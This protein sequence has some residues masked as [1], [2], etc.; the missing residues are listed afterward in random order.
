MIEFTGERV[1]PGQVDPDLWNEHYS[2]YL[3]AARL[4]RY[5]RVVDLGCGA[6][7][8]SALLAQS[9][10]QVI[11]VDF[12]ADAV[13][14]A[15]EANSHLAQVHTLQASASQ[16]PLAPNSA[17]LAVAFEVIE[18]LD[19]WAGL[20]REARRILAPGG[21]FI[22]STPNKDYYNTQRGAHGPNPFHTHEFTFPEFRDALREVFPHVSL[23]VQNHSAGVVFRPL[24]LAASAD[25]KLEFG[26]P[27]PATAH[28]Y[29]AVC[30][31]SPQTGSPNFVY[32]PSAANV[33]KEREDHIGSLADELKTK[34]EWLAQA[35]AEHAELVELFR[36]QKAK[37]EESNRWADRAAADAKTAQQRN[38]QLQEELATEQRRGAQVVGQYEKR[39]QELERE[40]KDAGHAVQE[41]DG[42]WAAELARTREAFEQ[43]GAEVDAKT[44]ELAECVKLLDQAEATVVERTKWA[45]LLEQRALLLENRLG[46][47]EAS[48]WVK[49]GKSFGLGP[50][51][52]S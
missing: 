3:F 20:I 40:L 31:A 22:V 32:I 12:A 17:D 15:R 39:I 1:I 11:S 8:G 16:L 18:H 38:A 6:G 36:L 21:Q 44:R 4:A 42:R 25:V 45:Q 23:F 14:L 50:R 24:E 7:Y 9:A 43:R 28:F 5:R 51:L 46:A 35:R 37:L 49:L 29:V 26:T 34:D 19:D 10:R 33:L 48:R 30:A 47:V 13:T 52:D 2:R 27:D 41:A